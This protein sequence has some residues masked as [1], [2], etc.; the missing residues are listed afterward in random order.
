MEN[1]KI[2]T[3]LIFLISCGSVTK[4]DSA[5]RVIERAKKEEI[6]VATLNG[7]LIRKIIVK[8]LHEIKG[9]YERQMSSSGKTYKGLV[10]MKFTIIE[11]GQVNRARVVSLDPNFPGPI[12]KCVTSVLK[13]IECPRSEGGVVEVSQPFNFSPSKS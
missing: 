2:I 12:G 8:N 9:C 7:K 11:S 1:F 4:R 6:V 5:G 10:T 3:I 13:G